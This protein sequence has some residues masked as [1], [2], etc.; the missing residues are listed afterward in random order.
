[1]FLCLALINFCIYLTVTVYTPTIPTTA[2]FNMSN[3]SLINV[4]HVMCLFL[5]L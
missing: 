3:F 1:M 2:D 5:Y 4:F